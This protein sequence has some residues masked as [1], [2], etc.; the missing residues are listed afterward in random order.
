MSATDFLCTNTYWVFNNNNMLTF[1]LARVLL[2]FQTSSHLILEINYR[3][4]TVIIH[5]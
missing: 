5:I 3:V 4:S 2:T 1:I